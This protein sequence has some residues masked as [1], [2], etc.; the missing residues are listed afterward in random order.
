MPLAP[1]SRPGVK[2]AYC[3]VADMN[4]VACGDWT[5]GLDGSTS[6]ETAEKVMYRG[7]GWLSGGEGTEV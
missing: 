1:P 6:L 3:G 5:E 2:G 7:Q 4:A